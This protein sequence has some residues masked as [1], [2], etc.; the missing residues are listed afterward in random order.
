[1]PRPQGLAVFGGCSQSE[2]H[3]RL[4]TSLKILQHES[5]PSLTR[6]S[7][8]SN[9][10]R[11]ESFNKREAWNKLSEAEQRLFVLGKDSKHSHRLCKPPR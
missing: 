2:A 11:M 8:M 4:E 10:H 6:W 5:T 9:E 1:M 7:T 3:K